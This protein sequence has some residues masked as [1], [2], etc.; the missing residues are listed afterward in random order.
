MHTR[1]YALLLAAVLAFGSTACAQES[2]D[3]TT[4]AVTEATTEASAGT[5]QSA[6][7]A[8]ATADRAAAQQEKGV[9]TLSDK[10]TDYE[11]QINDDILK[12]PMMLPEFEALGWE[13]SDDLTETLEPNTY[14]M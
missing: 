8:D 6:A 10:W 7:K 3:G 2:T 11:L 5:A 9:A 12:F 13:A 4:E 1:R 14:S